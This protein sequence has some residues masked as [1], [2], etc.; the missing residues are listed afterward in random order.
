METRVRFI[1]VGAFA[2]A[3]I[4][5]VFLFAFW[6][7]GSGGLANTRALRVEF[8]G[9][10]LLLNAGEFCLLPARRC[11]TRVAAAEAAAFLNVWRG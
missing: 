6:I 3:A 11:E 1:I 4:V 2:L 8:E 7:H 5:G 10:E 9:G